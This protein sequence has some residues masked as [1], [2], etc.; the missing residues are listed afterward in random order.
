MSNPGTYVIF[1]MAKF[2]PK[3]W[4]PSDEPGQ[5][6]NEERRESSEGSGDAVV[7]NRN[8]NMS[9]EQQRQR[10]QV[11]RYRSHILYLLENYQTLVLVGETGCG[12]STQLPQYLLE[13][14]WAC[15]GRMVA[16]TQP[17]R[18]A[19]LTVS[20]RVADE[21]DVVLGSEVGY[22]I[23][24]DECWDA[25][26]TKIKFVTDGLL[27]REMMHDPLLTAY[28]VVMLDE[29]HERTLY[30]DIVIGLLKKVTKKRPDLRVIVTSATLDAELFRDF[31]NNNDDNT[32]KDTA[33]VLS[34]EG[35]MFPVDVYYALDP[36]PNYLTASVET[37]VKLH[38]REN[39]GDV[40]VFV[41]GQE[42]VEQVV[43]RLIDEARRLPRDA[44]KM[45]VLP[46]YGSLPTSEQLKVFDRTPRGV[47][48]VIVA[49]NIAEASVTINGIVYVVDCGFV[50]LRAYNP[51]CGLESLVI[52]PTS[53][54]SAEQRAGRAGRVR[55]GQVEY[56]FFVCLRIYHDHNNVFTQL[57]HRRA[58]AFSMR[59]VCPGFFKLS[60]WALC[61][62]AKF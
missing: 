9:M 59:C 8:R 2:K 17:R 15:D 30:T 46:I 16:V 47:R 6:T 13:A 62:L 33:T 28:S 11:F 25:A 34:V 35:R 58:K 26:T 60:G 24:F 19:V 48:K 57:I 42:E 43:S 27:I 50:K 39:E 5:A 22:A 3:F 7:F 52:L 38:H 44:I 10:L 54:A 56:L 53:R 18:V 32:G 31:F 61:S 21:R 20:K 49:T 4:K 40:L 14:G 51:S 29:A 45:R 12:K 55:S 36:V 23:R 37:V 41:T 1:Q